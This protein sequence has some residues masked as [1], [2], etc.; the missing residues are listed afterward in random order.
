MNKKDTIFGKVISFEDLLLQNLHLR[1]AD[2]W[3]SVFISI[4]MIVYFF[5]IDTKHEM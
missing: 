5:P 2:G 4:L 3:R 1:R